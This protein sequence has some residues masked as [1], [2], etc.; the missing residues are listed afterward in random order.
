ME[1]QYYIWQDEEKVGPYSL[2]DLRNLWESGWLKLESSYTHDKAT[3]Y[4][5]VEQLMRH[6]E[7]QPAA[8]PD[9]QPQPQPVAVR[10]ED[11]MPLEV[12]KPAV[13]SFINVLAYLCFICSPIYLIWAIVAQNWWLAAI[14][15]SLFFSGALYYGFSLIIEYL[16][17]ISK[18]LDRR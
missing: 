4:M 11:L 5:P 16:N 14:G 13:C 7:L 8:K 17:Q 2:T 18:K 3:D 10:F 1:T 15:I 12:Q 9:A 6:F